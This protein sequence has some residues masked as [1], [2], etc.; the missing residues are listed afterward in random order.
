MNFD[1]KRLK[2]TKKSFLD[3]LFVP[4]AK[5]EDSPEQYANR[6][7]QFEALVKPEIMD[8][9]EFLPRLIDAHSGPKNSHEHRF[10]VMMGSTWISA[11]GCP[12][13]INN[14]DVENKSLFCQFI[15][16]GLSPNASVGR[17][18]VTA[19]IEYVRRATQATADAKARRFLT[20]LA[21][22]SDEQLHEYR[23]ALPDT[24]RASLDD[25]LPLIKRPK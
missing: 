1:L 18:I 9:S 25:L 13:T 19:S 4:D 14:M 3:A 6:S 17:E 16:T 10:V 11:T 8:L 2:L 5:F 24:H 12:P 7:L 21:E 20:K 15:D 22:M 23:E